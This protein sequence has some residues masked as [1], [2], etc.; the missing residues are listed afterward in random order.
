MSYIPP[1]QM[2]ELGP[3]NAA[4]AHP[5]S[6]VS[7]G[8]NV[9][10]MPPEATITPR[11]SV[12]EV[13]TDHNSAFP[14]ATPPSDTIPAEAKVTLDVQTTNVPD[15][16]AVIIS[17]RHCDTGEEIPNGALVGLVVQGNRVIDA[18][19]NNPPEFVFSAPHVPW[20][21]W[22]KPYFYFKVTIVGRNFETNRDFRATPT[23]CLRVK[24]WHQCIAESSTLSGVLPEANNVASILNG[25]TSSKAAV[26]N[27]TT[28]N[29]PRNQFGSLIRNTYVTHVASHGSVI[30]R[31]TGQSV[32]RVTRSQP[33]DD[34]PDPANWR[35]VVCITPGWAGDVEFGV[36]AQFPSMPKCLFYFSSCLTGWEPSCANAIMTR[37][38]E[39]V[40]AFR[41][42]IPDAEAP[43]MARKFYQR[44]AGYKLDPAKIPDVFFQV[45]PDHYDNMKPVLFGARGGRITSGR[46]LSAGAIAGIV[47]GALV[48]GAL[49]GVAAW[50]LLRK[51]D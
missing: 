15:R 12:Q 1:S 22:D 8:L 30:H 33:P 46:G 32:S 16:T 2:C 29:V 18:I 20:T 9:Q 34:V 36:A 38:C 4:P 35:S 28:M 26:Q 50:A 17:V 13:T 44:W 7:N 11:W 43:D 6:N 41:R 49:I 40:L 19:T 47:I 5:G 3:I 37:G 39:Y 23:D 24:Y 48:V 25:V 42:T 31:T 14:P 45:G 21:K 10:S 51:K 27:L